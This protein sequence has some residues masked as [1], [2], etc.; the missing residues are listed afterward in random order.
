MELQDVMRTRRMVH[1]V[2]PDRQAPVEVDGMTRFALFDLDNTLVDQNRA[3]VG[4]AQAFIADRGLDPAAVD[5]LDV[6]SSTASTWRE[7]AAGFKEHFGL[8]D[9]IDGLVYEVTE[10]YPRY[11]VLDDAVADGLRQL[12]NEGWK[13]GIV[14]NGATTMQNAKIQQVGLDTLVDAVVVSEA[15]GCRKPGRQIFEQVA[16]KL[17]TKLDHGG[18]MIGDSLETDV[19]GGIAAGLRTMWVSGGRAHPTHGPYPDYNCESITQAIKVLT[20]E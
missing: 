8:L 20:A 4:W 3:L 15:E 7:Y 1:A 10:T 16:A 14:T 6:K 11:F 13:L 9:S 2:D 5:W 19:A 17:G 12:R 18:W